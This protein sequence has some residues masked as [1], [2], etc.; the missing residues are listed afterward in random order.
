MLCCCYL[1]LDNQFEKTSKDL[2]DLEKKLKAMK[3]TSDLLKNFCP[4]L[5]NFSATKLNI[6]L[7][8]PGQYD[9]RKMPLVQHHVKIS[10]FCPNVS[11]LKVYCCYFLSLEKKFC[12]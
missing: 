11:D 4:W 5:A 2:I 7:E 8:I 1:L 9:G 6:D 10:G 12:R 3:K